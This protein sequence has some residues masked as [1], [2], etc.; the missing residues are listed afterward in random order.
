M[1]RIGSG[2]QLEQKQTQKLSPVQMQMVEILQMDSLELQQKIS[3]EMLENP[4]LEEMRDMPE[5]AEANSEPL[6]SDE[7]YFRDDEFMG[8]DFDNYDDS[9]KVPSGAAEYE[10]FS[11]KETTFHEHL[12]DQLMGTT[13]SKDV[14]EAAEVIIYSLDDDGYLDTDEDEIA[15]IYG[16]N[17]DC[18]I[19]ALAIVRRMG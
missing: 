18:I 13:C 7:F 16:F 5:D 11:H 14:R 10:K 19:E 17:A 3:E 12:L 9:D 1:A 4:V 2:L 15:K 8:S 6:E